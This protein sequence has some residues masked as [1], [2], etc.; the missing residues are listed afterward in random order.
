VNT[1]QP[2]GIP[3]EPPATPPPP[4]AA[5]PGAAAPPP[6]IAAPP[7]AEPSEPEKRL[8]TW[9]PLLYLR[10]ALLLA[11][12]AYSIAF[13]VKNSRQINVHFV[14]ATAK[15]RLIWEIL[16]LLAIG[17]VGGILLSQLYRHRRR[18][19]L[20]KKSGKAR[21]SGADLSGRDKAVGKPS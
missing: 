19:Q 10:I 6:P 18:A 17:L 21:H 8:S 15:V 2:P 14:F 20:A 1:P 12:I 4:P 13:V 9:Q 16:L 3:D 5:P 11:A 7:A